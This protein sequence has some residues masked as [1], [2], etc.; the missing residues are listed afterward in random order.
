MFPL[1]RYTTSRD[2]P[3]TEAAGIIAM[4]GVERQVNADPLALADAIAEGLAPE[5]ADALAM[6]LGRAAVVG[7]V[8]PEATLRRKR[9]A[10]ERLPREMSERLYEIGR[11]LDAAARVWHGDADA[12]G[13][14]LNRPHPL[15]N[16][17][18]PLDV[19]RTSSAGADAVI[20]LVR[21]ADAGFAV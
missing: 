5:A 7:P 12:I 1:L 2:R 20:D 15:L 13:R 18:T 9:L 11:V 10:G 3:A 4:L 16:G 14:F 8:I 6:I 21:R 17:R 19:A